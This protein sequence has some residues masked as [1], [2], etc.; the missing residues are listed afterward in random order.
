MLP[1]SAHL[2]MENFVHAV[3]PSTFIAAMTEIEQ[4]KQKLTVVVT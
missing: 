1:F 2:K 3:P 4:L